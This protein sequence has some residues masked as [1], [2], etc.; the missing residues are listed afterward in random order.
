MPSIPVL[1]LVLVL[2]LVLA[3]FAL[4]FWKPQ[5][6]FPVAMTGLLLLVVVMLSH[7]H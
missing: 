5:V 2:V 7:A 1:L 4:Y 6:G 3:G